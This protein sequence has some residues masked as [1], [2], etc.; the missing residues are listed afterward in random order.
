MEM[1]LKYLLMRLTKTV[2]GDP[3]ACCTSCFGGYCEESRPGL[4]LA[5]PV[6]GVGSPWLWYFRS[7]QEACSCSLSEPSAVGA[8]RS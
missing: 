5:A 6:V 2:E 3:A 4:Q 1:V 7:V 8:V